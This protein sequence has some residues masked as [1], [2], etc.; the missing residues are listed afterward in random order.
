MQ[1][2]K[3]ALLAALL[4]TAHAHEDD[5]AAVAVSKAVP[6]NVSVAE[7]KID[8]PVADIQWVGKDKKTVYVRSSKNIVYRSVDEG[9]TWEK[10]NWK[11]EK[12]STEEDGKTG[13]LSMHVSP[14]DSSKIFFRG[15]G[16]QH[17]LTLDKGDHYMPLDTAFSIKEIKMHPTESEW[18]L[19]SHLTDGCKIGRAH[20]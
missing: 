12:A 8:S 4:S 15:V 14:A 19:A 11:M 3:L 10:Q 20:V 1:G 7:Y 17:W 5:Q 6:A 9:R 18:M 13:I 16:K 2:R